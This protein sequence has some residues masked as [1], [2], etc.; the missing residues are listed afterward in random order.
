[1]RSQE[2]TNIR[3][4][5]KRCANYKRLLGLRIRRIREDIEEEHEEP[6]DRPTSIAHIIV[7]EVKPVHPIFITKR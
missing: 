1:M 6:R 4:L 5:W 7:G 2:E 3:N